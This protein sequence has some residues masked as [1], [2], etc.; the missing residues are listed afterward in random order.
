MKDYPPPF[1]LYSP[2]NS[3]GCRV[4]ALHHLRGISPNR[5]LYGDRLSE[6]WERWMGRT[7]QTCGHQWQERMP[8]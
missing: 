8:D 1:E 5:R 4:V 3:W 7:C 6:T 2:C